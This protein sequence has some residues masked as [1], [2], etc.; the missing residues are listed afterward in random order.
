M[1]QLKEFK[2]QKPA[3]PAR[4]RSVYVLNEDADYISGIDLTK[5]DKAAR[6]EFEKAADIF[7]AA[8]T[9]VTAFAYRKF[10]KYNILD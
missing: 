1:K 2:Y 5:L 9:K 3:E 4:H 8:V 10:R 7:E 6:E